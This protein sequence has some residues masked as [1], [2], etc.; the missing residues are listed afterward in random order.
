MKRIL[1][2]S[3][4]F[5]I[6]FSCGDNLEDHP[7]PSLPVYLEIDFQTPR[8]K[9]LKVPPSY[10]IYTSE[11]KKL[12]EYIGFGGVLVVYTM[13]YG[14]KAFDLACPLEAKRSVLVEMDDA[15]SA[16]CPSC[17]SKFEVILDSGSG[18]C[19]EGKAKYLRPYTVTQS[20]N[21]L[22]VRNNN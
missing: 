17:G 7:I 22:I 8:D 10:S 16:V 3:C 11:N 13:N 12:R 1:I 2:I 18:M 15:Y 4:F 14:Y 19:T 6:C 9:G 21:L 5:F 20:G